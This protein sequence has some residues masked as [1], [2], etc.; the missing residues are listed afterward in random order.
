MSA[1]FSEARTDVCPPWCVEHYT[2]EDGTQNHSGPMT[3]GV[4]GESASNGAPMEMHVWPELRVGPDGHIRPVGLIGETHRE[5]DDF[6]LTSEQL[7]RMAAHCIA[8]AQMCEE[9]AAKRNAV[10]DPVAG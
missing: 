5:P 9:A 7:R 3:R 10:T 1:T 4:V 8:V 6:E 2:G